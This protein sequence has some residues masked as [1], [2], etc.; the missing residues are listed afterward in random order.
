MPYNTRRALPDAASVRLD[1]RLTLRATDGRGLEAA[2]AFTLLSERA[3]DY[4]LSR[5]AELTWLDQQG[6]AAFY[7]L[8][9]QAP[10]L[11]YYTWTGVGQ[12]TN[13]TMTE[14]VIASLSALVGSCDREGGNIWTVP[15][16]TPAINAI[17]LLPPGQL[18]KALGL[19]ELPLGPPARG[20]ITAR[21]FVAAV[22]ENRAIR[23]GR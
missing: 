17:S 1:A 23:C 19:E 18:E 3:S 7:V 4:P 8:L 13:A 14:R 10:R 22:I 12:L 5:V 20:W 15:P 2:T 9:E 21:D 16:P 6:I 11:A